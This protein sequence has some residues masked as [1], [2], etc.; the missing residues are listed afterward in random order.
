MKSKNCLSGN[1]RL[2]Q[3]Q[4]HCAGRVA[5]RPSNFYWLATCLYS[6]YF[7]LTVAEEAAAIAAYYIRTETGVGLT[8]ANSANAHDESCPHDTARWYC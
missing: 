5:N 7:K 4:K 1:A 8:T 2:W 6:S 3:A